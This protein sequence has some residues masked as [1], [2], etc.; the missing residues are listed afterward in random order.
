MYLPFLKKKKK[1]LCVWSW[2]Y[3]GVIYAKDVTMDAHAYTVKIFY[4][5]NSQFIWISVGVTRNLISVQKGGEECW[6]CEPWQE[7]R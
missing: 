5:L 4:L 3:S 7:Q 6:G 2:Q 1:S